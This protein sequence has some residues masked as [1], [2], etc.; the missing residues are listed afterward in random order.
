MCNQITFGSSI[1]RFFVRLSLFIVLLILTRYSTAQPTVKIDTASINYNISSTANISIGNI[2][3]VLFQNLFYARID[4]KNWGNDLSLSYT[5]GSRG[6]NIQTENDWI[7]QNR[8]EIFNQYKVFPIFFLRLE[9][10]LLRKLDNRTQIGTG[11]G[12]HLFQD[13]LN[14][15]NLYTGLIFEKSSYSGMDATHRLRFA[16]IAESENKLK[17]KQIGFKEKVTILPSLNDNSGQ[18]LLLIAQISF[19]VPLMRHLSVA[20]N[21]NYSYETLIAEG[22]QRGNFFLTYGFVYTNQ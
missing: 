20:L 8:T 6:N 11:A 13:S 16:F 12:L 5:Y 4:R 14:K 10:N 22:T 3:R 21:S 9:T 15:I 17:G 2:Q 18:N 19:S 1:L 7:I